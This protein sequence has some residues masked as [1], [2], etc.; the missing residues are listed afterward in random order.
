[1]RERKIDML[2]FMK[3]KAVKTGNVFHG[4]PFINMF[5][6]KKCGSVSVE[7]VIYIKDDKE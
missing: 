7:E 6:D 2:D 1:M 3:F 5:G 4:I